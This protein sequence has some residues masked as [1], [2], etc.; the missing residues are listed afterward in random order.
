MAKVRDL[1]SLPV[2]KDVQVLA[3]KSGLDRNVEHITVMEVP[4]I[5]RWLKGNDFL[6]TS[7][8]SVRK[9]IEEQC[10]LIEELADTCCCVAVKIGQYVDKI[11]EE[12]KRK[13]DQC[14]LPLLEIPFHLSYIDILINVMDQ[15]FQ[16]ENTSSILGKYVKDILYDNYTDKVLMEERGHL[17][18]FD[19]DYDCFAAVNICFR[20]RYVPTEQE[21]KALR[22]F[23]Q[24]LQHSL[25]DDLKVTGCYMV[26]LDKG[27]L[28]LLEGKQE[29][30]IEAVVKR[31]I[32]E[33]E[34]NEFWKQEKMR[35]MCGIG[36]AGR[37]LTGIR[38]SYSMSFKAMNVGSML[39][40]DRLIYRYKELQLFCELEKFLRSSETDMFTD[41]LKPIRNPELLETLYMYFECGNSTELTAQKLYTHKNTIKYRLNRIQELTGMDLKKPDDNFR[42]YLAF[43]ANKLNSEK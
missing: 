19:V 18:G 1:L 30:E 11:P 28:L 13:A 8:Y 25:R 42:F 31:Y 16:E 36:P 10:R 12:V 9:G 3:G 40:R 14:N 17:F 26:K 33:S 35:M 15:I 6:I 7:F 39:Y 4:D 23:C 27:F 2:F 29:E 21:R 37:G 38:D 24:T 22:F 20:K 41:I 43:L 32:C 5:K 34:L